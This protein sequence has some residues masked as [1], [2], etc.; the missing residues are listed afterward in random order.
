MTMMVHDQ[1][2]SDSEAEEST[3]IRVLSSTYTTYGPFEYSKWASLYTWPTDKSS[4]DLLIY[5][6][7]SS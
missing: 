6:S 7:A 1:T 5:I 4:V 2:E 3:D